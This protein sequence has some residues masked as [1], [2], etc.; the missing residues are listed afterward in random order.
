M[1]NIIKA[2]EILNSGKYT[3]VLV[4]GDSVYTSTER[5][6]KPLLTWLDDVIYLKGYSA[7]DKVVGKAAAFLYVLLGVE[8]VYA[9]VISKPSV[10]VFQTYGIKFSYDTLVDAIKNR[11]DTGFCPMEQAVKDISSPSN[12]LKAVKETL[13]N[14]NTK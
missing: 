4:D 11:T 12:A 3:C 6:V 9:S 2:K 10:E 7:A 13:K 8:E 14:L 1:S 5:G